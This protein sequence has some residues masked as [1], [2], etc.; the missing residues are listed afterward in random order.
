MKLTIIYDN[1]T[2]TDEIKPDWGF[3]TLVETEG[4]N[5]LFDT[6]AH[7]NILL[8]NM[9]VLKIDPGKVDSVFISHDHWDHTGGLKALLEANPNLGSSIY[10]PDLSEGPREFNDGLITTG[11]LGGGVIEEQSLLIRGK[12]GLVVLV[13][14]SHP[15]LDRIIELASGFG[16]IH[17]VIGGFHGFNRFDAL[18]NIPLILPCHCTRH[19]E[20]IHELFPD[21]ASKCGAGR[22]I[23]I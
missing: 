5:L 19:K 12:E 18:K 15:G 20:K 9:D 7:G 13:G 6:G 22:V 1:D 11:P 16:K 8:G 3:S 10:Y 21:T 23:V 4:S 14:C 2:T 17:A